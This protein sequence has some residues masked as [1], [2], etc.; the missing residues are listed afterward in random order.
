MSF[1]RLCRRKRNIGNSFRYLVL[2][3]I[4]STSLD[5]LPILHRFHPAVVFEVT[6]LVVAHCDFRC[7]CLRIFHFHPSPLPS[8]S[9]SSLRSSTQ[10]TVVLF[11]C[12]VFCLLF[13]FLS[14]IISSFF[15]PYP[16]HTLPDFLPSFSS[17][18][19]WSLSFVEDISSFFVLLP[20]SCLH[21]SKSV[22]FPLFM[23]SFV[24]PFRP[25]LRTLC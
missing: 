23:S 15:S 17:A 12:V 14:C 20:S 25:S 21:S 3:S 4:S 24:P 18:F 13:F 8:S 22:R 16:R 11:M 6:F 10:R 2:I 9:E 19:S 5:V 7:M 1:R